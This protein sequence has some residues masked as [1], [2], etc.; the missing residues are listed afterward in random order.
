FVD[1]DMEF[2]LLDGIEMSFPVG[3]HVT[4]RIDSESMY[5]VGATVWF[6]V[7]RFCDKVGSLPE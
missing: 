5:T 4:A 2:E 7:C 3:K 6:R 1:G